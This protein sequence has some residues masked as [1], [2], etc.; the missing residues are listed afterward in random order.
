MSESAQLQTFSWIGRGE[1]NS[2]ETMLRQAKDITHGLSVVLR[3][4]E[5]E[6]WTRNDKHGNPILTVMDA[7][8][9]QRMCISSLEAFA[10]LCDLYFEQI[11]ETE[12]RANGR[13]V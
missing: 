12:D 6:E 5:Q 8:H 10:N 4:L 3:L 13:S 11:N 2:D 7:G 1:N 9:L